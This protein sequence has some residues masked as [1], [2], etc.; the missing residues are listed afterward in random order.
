MAYHNKITMNSETLIVNYLASHP[1]TQS[2][3]HFLCEKLGVGSKGCTQCITSRNKRE[4]TAQFSVAK[5]YLPRFNAS[6][7]EVVWRSFCSVEGDEICH[8]EIICV[9]WGW[10]K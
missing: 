10:Q 3:R 2:I 1:A 4:N 9:R 5:G 8:E 6:D 7:M